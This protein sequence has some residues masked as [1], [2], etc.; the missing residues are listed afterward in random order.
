MVPALNEAAHIGE[1]LEQLLDGVAAAEPI[2]VWVLDGGSNDGTQDVVRRHAQA[3]T[4]VRLIDNPGRT[5]SHAVNLAAKLAIAKNDITYLV[6]ADAHCRY[7]ARFVSDLRETLEREQADSV[8]V[9]MRTVGGGK[10]RDAAADLYNSW[11]GNGGSAHR[12]GAYRGWVDHGHH[13]LFLLSAFLATGGYDVAFRAN[14][15]AEFDVRFAARG[16]RIFLESG[17]PLEYI[18]RD[19]LLAFCRQMWRNGRYRVKT[20]V[21][22][23]RLLGL[24]QLMPTAAA[25]VVCGSVVCGAVVHPWFFLPAGVYLALV[26]AAALLSV[27]RKDPLHIGRVITLAIIS[28]MMFGWGAM[29]SLAQCYAIDPA[30]RRRLRLGSLPG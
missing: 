20:A 29:A 6:R 5:Q 4:R 24:R 13:A 27:S 9:P 30:A 18:P 21:K 2:E 1:M 10:I 26:S 17:A 15:D 19:T 8:V 23:R 16:Y 22:H 7:P 28:H 11:L 14:E 12:T 3:D 25:V